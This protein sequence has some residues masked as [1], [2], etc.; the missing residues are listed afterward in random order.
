MIRNELGKVVCGGSTKKAPIFSGVLVA[1]AAV[2]VSLVVLVGAKPAEAAFPGTNGKIAYYRAFDSWAKNANLA[3]QE[4]KLLDDA[5]DPAY[6]PDGSRVA[7]ERA[8]EIYVANA[9]GTGTLRRLTNDCLLDSAPVWSHDGTRIAFVRRSDD[10]PRSLCDGDYNIWTMNADGTNER[11]MTSEGGFSSPSWSVPVLPDAPDGKIL[12]KGGGLDMWTM[13]PDGSGKAKLFYTCPTENGICDNASGNPTFSPD[14]KEI[15][16][17][18]FGDIFVIPSGGGESRVILG[19]PKDGYPGSEEDPTWSPDG[20]RIAF[21]HNDIG[22]S[23]SDGISWAK[24]DG[25]SAAPTQLTNN[26]GEQDPDW[27]PMP[28]CT[29]R[30]NANNDPLIGT[31]G[32]DILCGDARN[33]TINGVG[34]NDIV[35]A[36]GGNDRLTGG[37]GNDTL[38]GGPGVD[39]ALYSGTTAVNANL[40]TEFATGVGLDV[41]LSVENLSGSSAGDRLTGSA[42]AN[43]L[44]GGGGADSMFGVGGNDTVNSKDGVNG[45]DALNGG[46]GT[47]TKTTDA[48]EK[49]I[50]GF[51]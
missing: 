15:A 48:T 13:N 21:E 9:N 41:L 43:A 23:G 2:A 5:G 20:T 16:A 35:L 27:Q 39:T 51:P 46:A 8:N 37:P 33:N 42:V 31:T 45:N 22:G 11:Q 14:G 7:F 3:A 44:V 6:S 49:S 4:T 25:T 19:T 50:V 47:D 26:A 10:D 38:N 24:A 36:Q 40:T 18:Y 12:Y 1:A 17:E 30:V 32:K 28:V 29:K 34:G